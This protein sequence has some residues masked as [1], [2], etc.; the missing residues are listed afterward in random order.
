MI[1]LILYATFRGEGQVEKLE[2]H[3]HCWGVWIGGVRLVRQ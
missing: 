3:S 1:V 2:I